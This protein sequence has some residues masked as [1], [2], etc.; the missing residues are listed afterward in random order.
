M[1]WE[2]RVRAGSAA[3]GAPR[4]RLNGL[5]AAVV[6]AVAFVR[7]VQVAVDQVINVVAVRDGFMPAVR[8]VDV[9]GLMASAGVVGSAGS[10]V[11]R[12]DLNH[13]LIEVIAMRRV[14]MAVVQIVNMVTMPDCGVA[15]ALSV[16]VGMTGMNA[17]FAH[18]DFPFGV[19]GWRIGAA[20]GA[21][22]SLA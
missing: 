12:A 15:A 14:Q 10:G 17:V 11:G 22:A 4:S 18:R 9:V 7:M 1:L 16:Y 6:V 20:A 2:P 13:M 3:S 19:L 8:A 21:G 5:Q